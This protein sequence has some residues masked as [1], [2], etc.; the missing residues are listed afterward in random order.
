M[1]VGWLVYDHIWFI[2]YRIR[3]TQVPTNMNILSILFPHLRT[4]DAYPKC[5]ARAIFPNLSPPNLLV[6]LANK[7]QTNL[8]T[9]RV[10]GSTTKPEQSIGLCGSPKKQCQWKIRTDQWNSCCFQWFF[11]SFQCYMTIGQNLGPLEQQNSWHMDVLPQQLSIQLFDTT[12]L[13]KS[14]FH[15]ER[16]VLT[17]QGQPSLRQAPQKTNRPWPGAWHN[18][19][20]EK[21]RILSPKKRWFIRW[22]RSGI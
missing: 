3:Y 9:L 8:N 17:R 16:L 22:V 19:E 12:Y 13:Y 7:C 2:W 15:C 6:H 18:L 10:K 14:W 11:N 21:W 20:W 4:H 5:W 1:H